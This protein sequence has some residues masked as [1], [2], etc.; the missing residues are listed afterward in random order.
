MNCIRIVPEIG[1]AFYLYWHHFDKCSLEDS[2]REAEFI[3]Q[4]LKDAYFVPGV[5][6]NPKQKLA[7]R[8][9]K[10]VRAF[11]RVNFGVDLRYQKSLH[12]K[13]HAGQ[14]DTLYGY[15]LRIQDLKANVNY[16]GDLLIPESKRPALSYHF[17]K[18]FKESLK[19]KRLLLSSNEAVG[20]SLLES[21]RA[22]S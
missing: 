10:D 15:R 6:S 19:K 13:V 16:T 21:K 2:F 18:G 14:K 11:V 7:E 22:L 9:L 3:P 8:L 17:F 12:K 1:I 5:S 20:Q 4:E